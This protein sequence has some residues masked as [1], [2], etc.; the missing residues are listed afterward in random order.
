MRHG[1]VPAHGLGR[2]AQIGVGLHGR[3]EML[4]EHAVDLHA[5]AVHRRFDNRLDVVGV[6]QIITAQ[7]NAA[8]VA[9]VGAPVARR[10]ARR[11]LE[12]LIIVVALLEILAVGEEVEGLEVRLGL[13]ADGC[14][15]PG[16]KEVGGEIVPPRAA[17]LDLDEVGG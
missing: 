9:P 13:G 7:R 2:G 8:A 11:Q 6:H 12:H 16:V 10:G 17:P 4:E 14:L 5:V 15:A 3:L 1:L